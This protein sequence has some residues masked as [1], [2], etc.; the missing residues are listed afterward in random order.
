MELTK[1]L[2]WRGAHALE[3]TGRTANETIELRDL[4]IS[5]THLREPVTWTKSPDEGLAST[6]KIIIHTEFATHHVVIQSVNGVFALPT[7]C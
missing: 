3:E 6:N 7:E 4:G 5:E 2:L 1:A